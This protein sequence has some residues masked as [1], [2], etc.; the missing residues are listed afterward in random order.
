MSNQRG[1]VDLGSTVR[2]ETRFRPILEVL[3]FNRAPT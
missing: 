3:M 1:N 2:D